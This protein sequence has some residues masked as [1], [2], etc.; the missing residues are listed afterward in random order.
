[1]Q[2]EILGN[3]KYLK[4]L[5]YIIYL[6]QNVVSAWLLEEASPTEKISNT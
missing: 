2:L 4:H 5:C 1:M 6:V 3:S